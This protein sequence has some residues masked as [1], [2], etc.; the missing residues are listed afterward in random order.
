MT[1]TW[2][3]WVLCLAVL[4]GMALVVLSQV[5]AGSVRVRWPGIVHGSLGLAG[6]VLLLAGL[7]GPARG[8]QQGA[9]S[10]GYIAAGFVGSAVLLGL[11]VF[12]ARIRRRA[13]SMLAVGV[14]ATLAVGGLVMLAAYL[15]A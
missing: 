1:L 8:A 6:F 4:G 13:P 12:A 10:F 3:A 2:S 9:G 15:A 14:H 11:V 5:S 7:G